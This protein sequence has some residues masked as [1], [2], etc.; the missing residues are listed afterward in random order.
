MKNKIILILILIIIILALL[1][2]KSIKKEGALVTS[3]P[4]PKAK[5]TKKVYKVAIVLD[6][7]GY[8]LNNLEML[9]TFKFPLTLAILPNLRYSRKIS[10]EA[11]NLD[12]EIILHLPLEPY[13]NTEIALEENTIMID[14]DK[15]EI[16]AILRRDLENLSY[17]VGVSNHQGS[18]LTRNERAIKIIFE[19][20]KKREL[21]FLDSLTS[22][23]SLCKKIAKE[24]GV[25]FTSR[26]VFLDNNPSEKYIE[27]QLDRLVKKAKSKGAAVG[28]G[29]NRSLTLKVLKRLMPELEKKEGIKFV[30]V[31]ELVK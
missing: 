6:D 13:T 28:I 24:S 1:L 31:S 25:K 11:H 15:D 27:G 23:K 8:N 14:M 22:N 5:I 21:F 30:F 18:K 10:Q 9:K 2:V 29:H 16:L 19:E 26:S 4:K 3:P 20:F 7:W 17:A 12:K